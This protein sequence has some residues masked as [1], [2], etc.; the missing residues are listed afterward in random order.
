LIKERETSGGGKVN[1]NFPLSELRRRGMWIGNYPERAV[2]F[3][4]GVKRGEDSQKVAAGSDAK[5]KGRKMLPSPVGTKTG[6]ISGCRQDPS[7]L[8]TKGKY[9]A[10]R[11]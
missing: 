2:Y 8:H 7:I 6:V 5:P 9:Y 1:S 11:D 10:I 3:G 4:R